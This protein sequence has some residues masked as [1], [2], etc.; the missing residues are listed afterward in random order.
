MQGLVNEEEGK[1]VGKRP[2][3]GKGEGTQENFQMRSATEKIQG[4]SISLIHKTQI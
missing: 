2:T 1:E 4:S 3:I